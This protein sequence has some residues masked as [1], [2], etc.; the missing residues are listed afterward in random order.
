M[1]L[2]KYVE[3]NARFTVT[4]I[5]KGGTLGGNDDLDTFFAENSER[6]GSVWDFIV[7]GKTEWDKQ[8]TNA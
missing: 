8:T 5:Q 7:G 6:I 3:E 2:V 4:H 1:Y